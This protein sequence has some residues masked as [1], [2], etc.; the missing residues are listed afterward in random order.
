MLFFVLQFVL[1]FS[2][3]DLLLKHYCANVQ[4]K[5]KKRNH[6]TKRIFCIITILISTPR[7]FMYNIKP[8]IEF[9]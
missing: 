5:K 6:L 8:L 1:V 3:M 4:K 9:C 2:H 7:F